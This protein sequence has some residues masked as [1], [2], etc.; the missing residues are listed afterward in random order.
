[1]KWCL[2]N[3]IAKECLEIRYGFL[4]LFYPRVCEVCG[5]SLIRG[6]VYLCSY[7]LSDFPFVDHNMSVGKEILDHF[8]EQ[9]R[10]IRFYALYYYDKYS[11]FKNLI[12]QVKY[13]SYQKL[14]FYLGRM[15]G[16]RIVA[17]CQVDCIIPVP[18]HEKKKKQ[19]G[20]NQALE[21]AKGMNEV[22]QVELLEQV[23]ASKK[24]SNLPPKKEYIPLTLEAFDEK[25]P[26]LKYKYRNRE[27]WCRGYY[28]D[29]AGKNTQKI[30][31]YIQKQLE[32]D[33]AGE[34]LTMPNF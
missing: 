26:E 12:Y 22:L 33:K 7:C 32:E 23:V 6:E 30:Q 24:V 21:I 20:Y 13:H 34:Q 15:L 4:D 17:D 14:A 29:T 19:R 25:Y 31:E 3:Q 11:A 10:P 28:V 2:G 9:M 8:E 1:M 27:F 16:E 18:L 5:K